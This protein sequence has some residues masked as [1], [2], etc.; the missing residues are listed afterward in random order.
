MAPGR[1]EG[2]LLNERV[3]HSASLL[4]VLYMSVTA[5]EKPVPGTQLLG[6]PAQL[7]EKQRQEKEDPAPNFWLGGL[8]LT[9]R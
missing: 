4:C 3:G 8:S 5:A 6:G 7:T 9:C 1:L 2:L